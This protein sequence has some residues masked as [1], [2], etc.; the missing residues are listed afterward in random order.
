V[1]I[2]HPTRLVSLF[3]LALLLPQ[4][5]EA[6]GSAQ[7]QRLGALLLRNI[8]RLEETFFRYSLGFR[9]ASSDLS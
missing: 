4:S 2:A 9:A 1:G 8:N 3:L 7:F 5:R 6:R